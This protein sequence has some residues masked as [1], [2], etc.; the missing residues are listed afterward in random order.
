MLGLATTV[1]CNIIPDSLGQMFY[2]RGDLGEYIRI[3]SLSA[4]IF[5]TSSTMFG[6]LNGLNKQG[7]ILRN[8][9]IVSILELICLFI[10]IGI[11]G[12]NI[13]GYGITL[14]LTSS[15]SLFINLREV[16]KH[17]YLD[18]SKSN[19]SIFLLLSVL[20]FMIL[21]LF[22]NNFLSDLFI[23]K[24]LVIISLTFLI[25]TGLSFFGIDEE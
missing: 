6:I 7:V 11:P 15:V 18:L 25:F 23:I 16:Q 4:P 20:I 3:A 14:F 17:I 9:L 13:M 24:N 22:T 2:S 8:S 5:F 1:I 21:R 12:V 10:F 19:I